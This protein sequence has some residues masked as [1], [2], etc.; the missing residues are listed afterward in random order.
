MSLVP[1]IAAILISLKDLHSAVVRCLI[2]IS[3]N[4]IMANILQPNTTG[5]LHYYVCNRLLRDYRAIFTTLSAEKCYMPLI[6]HMAVS[7][8]PP[9]QL[10]SLHLP[11]VKISRYPSMT[12]RT[13]GIASDPAEN[14]QDAWVF[15]TH[16]ILAVGTCK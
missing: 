2:T 16:V 4:Q 8:T 7:W 11:L 13:C 5:R 1:H 14:T 3:E 10:Q 12:P 6:A 15:L 9:P